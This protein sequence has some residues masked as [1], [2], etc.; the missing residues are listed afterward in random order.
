MDRFDELLLKARAEMMGQTPT[1]NK[2]SKQDAFDMAWDITKRRTQMAMGFAQRA[3]EAEA[4][5]QAKEAKRQERANRPSLRDRFVSGV[6]SVRPQQSTPTED[7][8]FVDFMGQQGGLETPQATRVS[9]SPRT[10]NDFM[11]Q[12]GGLETPQALDPEEVPMREDINTEQP[13]APAP[14]PSPV[15]TERAQSLPPTMRP[16][17]V[18]PSKLARNMGAPSD[19][20]MFNALSTLNPKGQSPAEIMAQM[21][22]RREN[23]RNKPNEQVRPLSSA[24][25]PTTKPQEE[26]SE[27]TQG[28]IGDRKGSDEGW[29]AYEEYNTA[30][31]RRQQYVD[32]IAAQVESGQ[33]TEDEAMEVWDD[34]QRRTPEVRVPDLA[35]L[36]FPK[37]EP[38]SLDE[39]TQKLVGG[40]LKPNQKREAVEPTRQKTT[41]QEYKR[42]IN[43][44]NLP[45]PTQKPTNTALSTRGEEKIEPLDEIP[46]QD[47]SVRQLGSG[48]IRNPLQLGVGRSPRQL[49]EGGEQRTSQAK[50]GRKLERPNPNII[51]NFKRPKRKRTPKEKEPQ[52]VEEQSEPVNQTEP[53]VEEQATELP[54]TQ[55]T[56]LFGGGEASAPVEDKATET[57][58]TERS[59]RRK[60]TRGNN[61]EATTKVGGEKGG[62]NEQQQSLP[63]ISSTTDTEVLNELMDRAEE[64]DEAARKHLYNS[65][66]DLEDHHPSVAERFND[67][68]GKMIQDADLSLLPSGMRNSLLKDNNA[69]VNYSLLPNGWV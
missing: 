12:Q 32:A 7:P 24:D 28:N 9:G 6:K 65:M 33:M 34:I 39:A 11:G 3:K 8:N 21:G 41:T 31:K 60:K 35:S 48:P 17:G 54:T 23:S 45:V 52:Q 10:F 59:E 49:T 55:Q 5:R 37:E 69:N 62:S 29:D 40:E 19:Q 61:T 43:R 20:R 14:A 53:Q 26:L 47:G 13:P 63:R 67:A 57:A 22:Q 51:D 46:M 30:V 25:V 16:G 44:N 2:I 42:P 15:E 58:A 66:G 27:R 64:G 56:T 68:F 4:K 36:E 1:R 18:S 50:A 38:M